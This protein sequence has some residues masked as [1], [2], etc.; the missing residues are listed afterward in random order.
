MITGMLCFSAPWVAR[1]A[2]AAEAAAQAAGS[3]LRRHAGRPARVGTKQHAVDLV[4]NVDREA[5]RVIRRRLLRAFP[6]VGFLGEEHGARGTTD[7][8]WIV[9]PIDGTMNFVHGVPIF[10]VS[11]GLEVAGRMVVGA[12]YDPMR[13]EMFTAVHGRGARL[14][15]RRMRVSQTSAL[16]DSLLSTGFNAAF[17]RN[18][19]PYL[20]WFTALESRS[21]AVRRIGSTCICLAYIASG[22]LDGFYEQDLKPWDIAAG[23]LLVEE[24]G[25]RLSTLTGAPA[26]VDDGRLLATNGRIHQAILRVLTSR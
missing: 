23:L 18:H 1:A 21:H 25:G 9:D 24:A 19:Q 4:T 7:A 12:I 11:I 2:A 16:S 15:G 5:E 10:A 14:N 8:R 17:R 26:R 3:L 6:S 13:E 22:R 20:R